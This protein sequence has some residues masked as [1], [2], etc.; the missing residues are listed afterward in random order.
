VPDGAFLVTGP[1]VTDSK[2]L[3][4]S[5]R[6]LGSYTWINP[7]GDFDMGIEIGTSGIEEDDI[8]STTFVLSHA[9][10]SLTVEQFEFQ[11]FGVRLSNVGPA[12]TRRSYLTYSKL[13]GAFSQSMPEPTVWPVATLLCAIMPTCR[14]T[15][16]RKIRTERALRHR[17]LMRLNSVPSFE[18]SQQ[19]C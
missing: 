19:W 16:D 15:R 2:F 13:T 8:Q 11:D 3:A 12:G 6:R 7:H 9:T 1:E 4:N 10:A 18:P 17:R 14:R 5:V